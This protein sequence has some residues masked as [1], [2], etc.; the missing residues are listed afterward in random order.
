[1]HQAIGAPA[2]LQQ[3]QRQAIF[4]ELWISLELDAYTGNL[5]GRLDSQRRQ[6]F[7]V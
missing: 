5:S 4:A 1:L 7:P 2:G 3:Q 6:P